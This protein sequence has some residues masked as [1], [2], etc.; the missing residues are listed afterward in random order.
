MVVYL[1]IHLVSAIIVIVVL[2]SSIL[3][4]LLVVLLSIIIVVV[5]VWL[6]PILVVCSNN[7]IIDSLIIAVF[8]ITLAR[9]RLANVVGSSVGNISFRVQATLRILLMLRLFLFLTKVVVHVHLLLIPI[10]ITVHIII[11]HLHLL[12]LLNWLLL[13]VIEAPTI[14]ILSILIF[15]IWLLFN[16]LSSNSGIVIWQVHIEIYSEK[17]LNLIS[18]YFCWLLLLLAWI[19]IVE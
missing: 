4:L 6:L 12:I 19:S 11:S 14:N 3:L 15:I 10:Y 2:V 18:L 9:W 16:R 17:I 7:A 13:G 1:V 5:V 8:S